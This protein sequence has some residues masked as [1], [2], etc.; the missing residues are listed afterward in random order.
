MHDRVFQVD[1]AGRYEHS[2]RCHT[3]HVPAVTPNDVEYLVGLAAALW[4]FPVLRFYVEDEVSG[5]R[6][7]SI[8]S[9]TRQTRRYSEALIFGIDL[10][11]D[12]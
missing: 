4:H 11:V 9:G 5:F 1:D 12:Q 10:G 6:A 3:E 7:R 8:I 2:F